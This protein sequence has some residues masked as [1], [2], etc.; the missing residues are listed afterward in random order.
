[1]QAGFNFPGQLVLILGSFPSTVSL[2][3]AHHTKV[4]SSGPETP[5]QEC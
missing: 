5:S 1:M 3:P 2:E 4:W